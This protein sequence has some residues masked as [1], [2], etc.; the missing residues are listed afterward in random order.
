MCPT[1]L[2]PTAEENPLSAL[3]E[4]NSVTSPTGNQSDL[5]EDTLPIDHGEDNFEQDKGI[6]KYNLNYL[7]YLTLNKKQMS[8]KQ[9]QEL[10]NELHH[11]CKEFNILVTKL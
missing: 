10:I 5:H 3:S 2:S 6:H 11:F 1:V 7:L 9:H 4:D 8:P